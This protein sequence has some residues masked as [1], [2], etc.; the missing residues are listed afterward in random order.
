MVSP[1]SRLLDASLV[2]T[3]FVHASKFDRRSPLTLDVR[4]PFAAL[5]AVLACAPS[6]T[7][8][9]PAPGCAGLSFTDP[10]GDA[11]EDI[12]GLGVGPPAAASLDLTAGWLREQDGR[13]TANIQVADL[14]L[15]TPGDS[16]AVW[17]FNWYAGAQRFYVQASND[18]RALA[19]SYG[20]YD[21]S[22]SSFRPDPTVPVSGS[23][24]TGPS[25]VVQIDL[26][27]R[28][29]QPGI[30]L[31]RPFAESAEEVAGGRAIADR[32]PDSLGG[33][34]FVVGGC[35]DAPPA[36]PAPPA[37]PRQPAKPTLPLRSVRVLGSAR[38][39][40]KRRSIGFKVRGLKTITR[41]Q[42]RL[43]G[44]RGRVY[45]AGGLRRLR[46][47][48]GLKLSLRKTVRLREGRYLLRATGRVGTRRLSAVIPVTVRR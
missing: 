12:F 6:A 4:V 39:A 29:A 13:L 41:L 40:S 15:T 47:V 9:T 5:A 46:G 48:S 44:D 43:T 2:A 26:P 17:T 10:R 38:K 37:A 14:S 35:L 22:S 16:R 28:H 42:V 19:Y 1:R 33:E 25:G 24:F 11:V 3:P 31:E 32:A 27:A 34:P 7:A 18:G 23:V 8:A 45:A 36:P 20:T 30:K 21:D